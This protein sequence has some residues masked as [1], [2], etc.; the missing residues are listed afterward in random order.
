[1]AN[2]KNNISSTKKNIPIGEKY[3]LTIHEA[4]AYFNIGIKNLR[5][6]A[7][8]NEGK[9]AFYMGNR[10]LIVRAKFE[11]YIEQLIMDGIEVKEDE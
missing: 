11:D 3:L 5:R 4:S 8:I 2:S 1:M 9:F 7:E 10:Y 6:M